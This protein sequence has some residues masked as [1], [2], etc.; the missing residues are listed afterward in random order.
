MRAPISS[1][2]FGEEGVEVEEGY[3][4]F[5]TLP[6]G[7]LMKVGKMRAAFGKVNTLHTHV[8][9]WTDRPLV[10]ENLR[11]RRGRHR[12][13]RH[14]GVAADS[15]PVDLPRGDRPGLSRRFA[16]TLFQSTKRGDLSYVGHLRGYQDVTESTNSISASRTRTATTRPASDRR[17]RRRRA[18][19]RRSSSASTRRS[20]GG[21]CGA[22][23]TTRFSAAAEFDL[24][25][26]R[27][28][29]RAA[30]RVR[31]LCVGRL[32]VRASLVH[33]RALRSIGS[34]RRRR[35]CTT[36]GGRSS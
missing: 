10:T 34:R 1:S 17:R 6:G 7:L 30:E 23:S 29:G 16:T 11:R 35:R 33:R 9:P 13:C 5:P 20:A 27:S 15:E 4:T 24:E 3:I 25:P 28:A 36:S 2:S 8:L 22:R 26:A 12:R 31:V 21:R 32:S 19:S 18:A 14:V